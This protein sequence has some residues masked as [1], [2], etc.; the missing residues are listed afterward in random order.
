MSGQVSMSGL[1]SPSS[2]RQNAQIS[3]WLARLAWLMLTV[4]GGFVLVGLWHFVMASEQGN[5][6]AMKSFQPYS[7]R[8][9]GAV[10]PGQAVDSVTRI[11]T[12]S[13]GIL[14]NVDLEVT[15]MVNENAPD[16]GEIIT[17]T[18]TATNHGP[19]EA[20][21]AHLADVL[22]PG[23][24]FG[25]YTATQGFYSDTSGLWNIGDMANTASATLVITAIVDSNAS[26]T[27]TNTAEELVADQF[28]TNPDNNEASAVISVTLTGADLAVT[29]AVNNATPKAGEVI[30]YTI[31]VINNGPDEATGVRLTDVLPAGVTFSRHTAIRGTYTYTDGFWSIGDLQAS[32]VVTLNIAA[33][34]DRCT[35]NTVI[36]NTASITAG[37][38]EATIICIPT[39]P[40]IS[41]YYLPIIYSDYVSPI[42]SPYSADFSDSENGWPDFEDSNDV[43]EFLLGYDGNKYLVHLKKASRV[44][45]DAP[46]SKLNNTY[47]VTISSHWEDESREES[48]YGIDFG[49]VTL[50]KGEFPYKSYLFVVDAVNQR[51]R[52]MYK[53][54]ATLN[55]ICINKDNVPIE[56]CWEPD[57]SKIRGGN[58]NVTAQNK[59]SVLCKPSRIEIYA[60]GESLWATDKPIYPCAGGLGIEVRATEAGHRA[61]FERFEVDC[62]ATNVLRTMQQAIQK[63]SSATLIEPLS[64]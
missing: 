63:Q 57:K 15:K 16:P 17:Y 7:E 54:D 31:T 10:G 59:L 58:D 4:L 14:C 56:N 1:V 6:Q 61:I 26:G 22:P 47:M 62:S 34:V 19:T 21:G 24:A 12:G 64:K 49:H 40:T 60:N 9:A 37:H 5:A 41:G 42:C 30:T 43:V 53:P 51:Y 36:T 39:I 23:I 32:E 18:I 45:V 29:K 52:L 27:I 33:T 8:S 13:P 50:P 46:I 20:T 3:R 38:A 44:I 28:D 2:F 48:E 25:G 35:H 55:R 11:V